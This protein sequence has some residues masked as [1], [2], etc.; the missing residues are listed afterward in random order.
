MT[1]TDKTLDVRELPPPKRHS[2]IFQTFDELEENSFFILVNDHDPK[3]LYYQFMHEREGMVNWEYVESGPQVWRV[4]ITKTA[5][6]E[7]L[8]PQG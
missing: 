5:P 8:R 2:L 4:R 7:G 3:P 1:E 6:G